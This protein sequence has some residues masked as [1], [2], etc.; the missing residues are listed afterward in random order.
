MVLST[1]LV[2]PSSWSCCPAGRATDYL[3]MAR[4][5]ITSGELCEALR[6]LPYFWVRA[7]L[8]LPQ[9]RKTERRS[10]LPANDLVEVS[11]STALTSEFRPKETL[12][13]KHGAAGFSQKQKCRT[14][15]AYNFCG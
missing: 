6:R 3:P 7:C 11:A 12:F 14:T 1:G 2:M 10:R 5:E 15:E 4:A 13:A 9:E 8:K